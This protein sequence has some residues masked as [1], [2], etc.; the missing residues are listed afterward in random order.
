MVAAYYA[1]EAGK[2]ICAIDVDVHKQLLLDET[3][4]LSISKRTTNVDNIKNRIR[5]AGKVLFGID[6]L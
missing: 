5:L 4:S 6:I 2:E 3:Y 1:I